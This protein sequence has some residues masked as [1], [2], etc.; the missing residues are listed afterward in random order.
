ED[1]IHKLNKK[2]REKVVPYPRSISLLPEYMIYE[3][4]N[5]ELTIN[6]TQIFSVLNWALKPNQHEGPAFIAHMLAIYNTDAP[7]VP[8]APK[9]SSHYEKTFSKAKSLELEVD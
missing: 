7:M 9:T 5:E 6:L 2:T 1:I 8:K 4:D 3:Y